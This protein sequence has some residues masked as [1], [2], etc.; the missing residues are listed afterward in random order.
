MAAGET[1]NASRESDGDQFESSSPPLQELLLFKTVESYWALPTSIVE[2]VFYLDNLTQVPLMPLAMQGL[3]NLSGEVVPVINLAALS[4]ESSS[5]WRAKDKRCILLKEDEDLR[6]GIL[7][8]DQIRIMGISAD[9]ITA[10]ESELSK[11]AFELEGEKV[12][13]L[14]P[15]KLAYHIRSI[16]RETILQAGIGQAG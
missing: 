15:S 9:R 4:G 8:E 5:V 12:V 16:I 13:Q 1:E 10:A 3:T 11:H 7:A 6:I 14:D 2:K